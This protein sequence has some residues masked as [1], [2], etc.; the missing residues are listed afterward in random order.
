MVKTTSFQTIT[1]K[2]KTIVVKA[3]CNNHA[4]MRSLIGCKEMSM[5]SNPEV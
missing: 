1:L 4:G 5:H 3:G 2:R